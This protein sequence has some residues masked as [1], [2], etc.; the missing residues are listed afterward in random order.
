[1]RHTNPIAYDERNRMWGIFGY[2]DVRSILENHSDFSFNPKVIINAS[3]VRRMDSML[4][5]TT[6][7]FSK[8]VS[9]LGSRIEEIVN[10]L[11]NRI[12][13]RG[14]MDLTRDLAYP[15]Q[16]A[17]IAD[18]LDVIHVFTFSSSL[19]TQFHMHL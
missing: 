6:S 12:I 17:V 1:M 16:V 2:R 4:K 3:D 11:V 14:E 18:L 10:D 19:K 9:V 8:S 13:E 5:M 7:A 15:L